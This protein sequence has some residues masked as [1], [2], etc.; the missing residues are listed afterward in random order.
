[1]LGRAHDDGIWACLC[2]LLHVNPSQNEDIRSGA[3]L[4]LVLGGV[5]LRSATR[6][7][8]SACWASWAD[9]LPMMFAR[10]TEVA[11]RLVWQLEGHPDSPFLSAAASSARV[12][13]GTMGF[14]PPSWQALCE[15]VRP[16]ML[17]LDE[18]EPVKSTS[19]QQK[20][21]YENCI[22]S[23]NNIHT[24]NEDNK[25]DTN[26]INKYNDANHDTRKLHL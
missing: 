14:D 11:S 4:L 19:P 25:H 22:Y 26:Y 20:N 7:S 8:I 18:F 24:S 5:G 16:H 1:M 3:N 6:T 21:G 17:E 23:M 12:L 15:G 10:H 9:C 2:T 13:S